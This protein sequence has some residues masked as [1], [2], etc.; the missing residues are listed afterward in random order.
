MGNAGFG[1]SQLHGRKDLRAEKPV[2]FTPRQIKAMAKMLEAKKRQD[3]RL[4]DALA[5]KAQ[6]ERQLNMRR[7]AH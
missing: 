4:A 3:K 7:L 5:Q 2:K 1:S 6:E